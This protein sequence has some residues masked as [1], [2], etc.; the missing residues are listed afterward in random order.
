MEA[1]LLLADFSLFFFSAAPIGALMHVA[2]GL[3]IS[4]CL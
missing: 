3:C 1:F 4:H 2:S